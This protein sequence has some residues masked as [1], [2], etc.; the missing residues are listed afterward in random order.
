WGDDESTSHAVPTAEQLIAAHLGERPPHSRPGKVVLLTSGT[1]GAPKGAN[2]SGGGPEELA[3]MLERIPWHGGE[4]IVVAA[5]TFHA[6]GFGQLVIAVT[7]AHTV[8][9]CRKFYPALTRP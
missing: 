2:R 1:T 6:W 5:P 8:V 9:L 3:A 7:M 4:T